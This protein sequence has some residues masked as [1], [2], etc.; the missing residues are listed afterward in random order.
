[1]F[2]LERLKLKN[3]NLGL[4]FQNRF[5][6]KS[7]SLKKK[8]KFFFNYNNYINSIFKD[9][10]TSNLVF[11][12]SF[13]LFEDSKDFKFLKLFYLKN[14][15][16]L[17]CSK[18]KINRKFNVFCKNLNEDLLNEDLLL[19]Y[20][21]DEVRF[22]GF[23]NKLTTLKNKIN[24]FFYDKFYNINN[25]KIFKINY[26]F[27]DIYFLEDFYFLDLYL[28]LFDFDTSINYN[29]FSL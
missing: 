26:K 17:Y 4:S 5:I 2:N 27:K 3:V 10:Y 29:L 25:Y 19:I 28:D 13:N 18:S 20:C 23:K 7:N 24:L 9:V 1:M 14:Y 22:K 12:N 8:K 11:S 21:N 6:K 15:N 16:N